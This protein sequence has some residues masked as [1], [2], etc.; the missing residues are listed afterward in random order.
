MHVGFAILALLLT[1]MAATASGPD[2][3]KLEATF[4]RIVRASRGEVGV[5]L[6]HL[7]S[8]ALF[9]IDG[10]EQFPMASVCKL[11][12]ALEMLKQ[13]SEG[14]LKLVF[15]KNGSRVVAIERSIAQLGAAAYEFFTGKPVPVAIKPRRR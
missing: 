3:S 12:I 2:L 13:V 7:E 11:P 14:K 15:V 4:Q 5:A 10:H 8:G 9:E 1:G 6:I